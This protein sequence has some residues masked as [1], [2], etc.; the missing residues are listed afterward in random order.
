[1][2]SIIHPEWNFERLSQVIGAAFEKY[3]SKLR[4]VIIS[5]DCRESILR[6]DHIDVKDQVV[7]GV[8]VIM[9]P[10]LDAGAVQFVLAED[11]IA[12]EQPL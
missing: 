11:E 7:E 2:S 9:E 12:A 1:M 3:G 6:I 5:I 4:E 10:F 8:R